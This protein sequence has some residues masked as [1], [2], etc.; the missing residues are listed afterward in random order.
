MQL[1]DEFETMDQ[2]NAEFPYFYGNIYPLP[3]PLIL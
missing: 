1:L 2:E 3:P